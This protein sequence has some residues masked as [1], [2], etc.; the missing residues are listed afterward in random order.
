M[1][2]PHQHTAAPAVHDRQRKL[3]DHAIEHGLSPALVAL[4]DEGA[5]GDRPVVGQAEQS[6]E[7]V[8]VVEPEV[9]Y[10]D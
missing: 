3:S 1:V 9:R 10:E 2:P 5:V 8:A 7:L 4:Q 6:R